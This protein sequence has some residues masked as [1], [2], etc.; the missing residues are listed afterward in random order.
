MWY[1]LIVIRQSL[2]L[3]P[4]VLAFLILLCCVTLL[5]NLLLLSSFRLKRTVQN[6]E[7]PLLTKPHPWVSPLVR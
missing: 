3:Y 1:V 4:L 2:N 7:L 5:Y 6:I